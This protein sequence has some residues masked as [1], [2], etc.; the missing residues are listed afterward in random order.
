MKVASHRFPSPHLGQ[1]DVQLVVRGGPRING[2][3]IRIDQRHEQVVHLL[4]SEKVNGGIAVVLGNVVG[5]HE[6]LCFAVPEKRR[7]VDV[8]KRMGIARVNHDISVLLEEIG[9]G[10]CHS[11]KVATLSV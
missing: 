1:V 7:P 8:G 6:P 4:R 5:Q 2:Q 10:C 3:R 11:V 9:G